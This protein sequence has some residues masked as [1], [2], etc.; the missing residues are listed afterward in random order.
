MKLRATL[1]SSALLVASGAVAAGPAASEPPVVLAVAADMR[2][3]AGPGEYD[4]ASYFRGACEAMAAV[5]GVTC[6]I[7]PGDVDPPSGVRWTL[8]TVLGGSFPW[9]PAAGNHDA[10]TP[11]DMAWLR[12]LNPEGTALPGVVNA[13]PAP[14]RETTYSF[15][16]GPA[17]VAV[18]DE[19]CDAGGDTAADGDVGDVLYDWLAA[20]LRATAKP[21]VLVVG[22][23]PAWVRPD[24]ENGT[25]RHL[26]TSLDKHPEHRDRFWALLAERGVRAYLTGH[27]HC[28][29]VTRVAGV[30]QIDVGHARGAGDTGTRSTFVVLRLSDRSASYETYRAV[31]PGGTYAVV[32]AGLLAGPQRPVRR[33][34]RP[35]SR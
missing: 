17:H 28:Y 30:W 35:V 33:A 6:L 10:E 3:F 29:S 15:D 24:A 7:S 16:L 5:G 11:A 31:G 9:Y 14:C 34:L 20:D 19:Y 25:V 26:G 32:D 23:E 2:S 22:H 18:L 8:D 21:H 13:G 1:L 4:S 12:A 27:T